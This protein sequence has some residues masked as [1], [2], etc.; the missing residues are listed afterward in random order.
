LRSL[1]VKSKAD[2][3][4][5]EVGGTVGDLENSYFIEAMREL[6]YEEGKQ[7]VCF[8]NV[9]YIFKPHSLGEYKSKAAQ[10]GL[11]T[12]M[13]LGVQPDIVVCRSEKPINEKIKEKISIFSNVPH[14]MSKIFITYL[15]FSEI[16]VLTKL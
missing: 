16:L 15:F 11:R 7:N 2:I 14:M 5:V 1:A 8:I 12:L 13:S 10:L 9:T 6:A 4:L 3:V